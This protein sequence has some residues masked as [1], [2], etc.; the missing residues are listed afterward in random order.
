MLA[1]NRF[2]R[3]LSDLRARY[4]LVILDTPPAL[5]VTDARIIA[6]LADA[7]VFAVRWDDTPRGAVL[8]GLRQMRSVGAPL[9]GTAMTMVDEAKVARYDYD[10]YQY[11]GAR[12]QKYYQPA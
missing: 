7:V 9:V 2:E 1:S 5:P 3:I 10:G 4:D 8:E 12:Y 6:K 11:Y